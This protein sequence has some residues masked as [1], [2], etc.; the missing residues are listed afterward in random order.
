MSY[1]KPEK[2]RYGSAM[3][4][5]TVEDYIMLAENDRQAAE[6]KKNTQFVVYTEKEAG[7]IKGKGRKVAEV[8]HLA[9]KIFEDAMV[10]S[11]KPRIKGDFN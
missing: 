7:M 4:N 10:L 3:Y 6:L 9:K 5:K 2:P 1:K 11:I 8:C